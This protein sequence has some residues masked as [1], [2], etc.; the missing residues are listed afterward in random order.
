[1]PNGHYFCFT[2]MGSKN[3]LIC[4]TVGILKYKSLPILSS[5]GLGRGNSCFSGHYFYGCFVVPGPVAGIVM[6]G[7]VTD[8]GGVM[9][10]VA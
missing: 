5:R 3:F 10:T 2:S 7:D 1:M 8:A 6:G 4:F 9:L